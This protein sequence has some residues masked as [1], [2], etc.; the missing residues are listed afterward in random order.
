MRDGFAIFTFLLSAF[1]PTNVVAM[2]ARSDSI[3]HCHVVGGEKLPAA[4]GGSAAVCAEI[5]RA[6]VKMAPG[7]AYSAEVNVLSRTRLSASL[8]ID[9][10]TLPDQHFAIMD[11]DLNPGAIQRF[12]ASIAEAIAAAAKV[13][14]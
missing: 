11:S 10:R 7:V 12:A 1:G 8:V 2:S 9:G 13:A 14:K 6:A 5:Q 3:G 4:S